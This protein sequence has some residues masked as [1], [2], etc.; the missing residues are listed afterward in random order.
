MTEDG[1]RL[2]EALLELQLLRDREA[3]NLRETRTLLECLEANT[4]APTP[5]AA[6]SAIFDSLSDRIGADLCL[7]VALS[8]DGSATVRASDAAHAVGRHLAP[9]FDLSR[10]P[11]N[12]LDH[13]AKGDGAAISTCRPMPGCSRSPSSPG[14][15]ASRSWR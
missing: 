13:A 10:R 15:D 14:R 5:E 1:E 2:R 4:A 3:R 7:L 11:R 9:P 6:L 12:L 8:E